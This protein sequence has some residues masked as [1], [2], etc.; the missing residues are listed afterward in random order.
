WD[1]GEHHQHR[2]VSTSRIGW[3]GPVRERALPYALL[4]AGRRAQ[5][6]PAPARPVPPLVQPSRSA[7]FATYGRVGR[8]PAPGRRC[9][10]GQPLLLKGLHQD[11]V[12]R[13]WPV[14][15]SASG[16]GA[17]FSNR[18]IPLST[19]ATRTVACRAAVYDDQNARRHLRTA[20]RR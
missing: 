11:R 5:R 15:L 2:P 20:S 10:R 12:W 16:I 14:I 4:V 8:R 19:A 3:L 18:A 17:Q 9:Q 1:R 13:P 6:R 7:A